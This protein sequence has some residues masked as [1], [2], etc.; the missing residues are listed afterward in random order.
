MFIRCK[1]DKH[2]CEAGFTNMSEGNKKYIGEYKSTDLDGNPIDVSKRI[3]WEFTEDASHN[4]QYIDDKVIDNIYD[5]DFIFTLAGEYGAR[6]GGKFNPE[7]LVTPAAA[8]SSIANNNGTFQWN[9]AADAMGYIIY[10]DGKYL[11]NTS[12]CTFT[13]ATYSASSTYTL[14]S[15]SQT[16]CLGELCN[17]MTS[18]IEETVAGD[19][20]IT[21]SADG[22]HFEE[23]TDARLYSMNGEL[24]SSAYGRCLDWNNTNKG[25]YILKAKNSSGKSMIKKIIRK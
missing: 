11:G 25:C 12:A 7:P 21:I 8:P 22:I 16:G 6:A 5:M 20:E 1:M 14:R 2:I 15:V 4:T 19:I 3:D 13:D 23:K 24:V 10:K 9:T 18:G 17:M